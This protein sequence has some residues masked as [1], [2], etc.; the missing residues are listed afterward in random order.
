MLI[1]FR[2]IVCLMFSFNRSWK[3]FQIG[4]SIPWSFERNYI[5]MYLKSRVQKSAGMTSKSKKH[6]K[7]LNRVVWLLLYC[8]AL[9]IHFFFNF[10]FHTLWLKYVLIRVQLTGNEAHSNYSKHIINFIMILPF[11]V[12][13]LFWQVFCLLLLCRK[14]LQTPSIS[15]KKKKYKFLL[16]PMREFP[17]ESR[18]AV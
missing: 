6:D 12:A 5:C 14:L 8:I 4:L 7:K 17:D 3:C 2:K 9:H 10:F 13:V 15:H 16:F 18:R 1:R 11:R